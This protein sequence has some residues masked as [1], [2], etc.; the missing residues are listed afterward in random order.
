[1]NLSKIAQCLKELGYEKLTEL[2]KSS[3]L[4]IVKGRKLLIIVAPTGSGK[5]E[6]AVIPIMLKIAYSKIPPIA[7]LYITPLRALNRDIERRLDRL[8]RCFE[9]DVGVRHGDTPASVRKN[10]AQ[11][12]PHIL[13]TTPETLNFILVN[14]ELRKH[15]VNLQ[16]IVIDELRDLVESKRGL[17]LLTTLYILERVLGSDLSIIALSATLHEEELVK[18]LLSFGGKKDVEVLRDPSIRKFDIQV[19]IPRCETPLCKEVVKEIGDERLSARIAEIFERVSNEQYVLLFTN[20][21]TLAESLGALI[22]SLSE[23]LNLKLSIDVHHGSLSRQ[24]RERVEREFRERRLNLLVSTSSLELGIDIGHVEYVIQYMSPRQVIRLVQ[25]V[26]RSRHRL[27]EVSRGE[28][29]SI[30]NPLHLLESAVI[31]WRAINGDIEREVLVDRP[32]DVLAYALSLYIHLNPRGVSKS[33]LYAFIKEHPLFSGLEEREFN[34]VVNY[35]VYTR[36]V[37]E[38]GGLLY[39]TRKT[40]LYIYKTSMI[41]S[42][43]EVQVV[44]VASGKRVGALDEEYVVVNINPGDV[45]ILAGRPWKVVSYDDENKKLYVELARDS[46]EQVIIPHWEG[47]NIPVEYE[48]AQIVGEIVQYVKVYNTLPEHIKSLIQSENPINLDVLKELGDKNTITIDHVKE[49][50]LVL[51]NVYGGSK[52]NALLRDLLRYVLKT[53]F[54]Y[55]KVNAQSTPYCIVLQIQGSLLGAGKSPIEVVREVF[56]EIYRYADREVI[57]AVARDSNQLL[58][59]IYQVAQRFGAISPETTRVNRHLLEAFVDTIIGVEALKE[60]LIRDYDI[61]SFTN[62]AQRVARG[63]VKVIFRVYDKLRDHHITLLG[64]IELPVLK[65]LPPLDRTAFMEKLLNR[66]VAL[67]CIRCGYYREDKVQELLKL[68]KYACPKCGFATLA[69]VKG[70]AQKEIELVKKL[71][72]GDKLNQEERRIHEELVNRALILYNYGDKALLA[73]S[74]PGVNSREAASIIKNYLSGADLFQLLYEYEK[75]FLKIKKYIREG[76]QAKTK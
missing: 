23:K 51:I 41:P 52:V 24:H 75:R 39:P 27:G 56:E 9:L 70:D 76:E 17:L 61:D 54:P 68:E 48:T 67:L 71:R 21:R 44:E 69:V 6:A 50:N 25:R 47:E 63:E 32:L 34:E 57:K 31:A 49:F 62:L 46:E 45:L 8:S 65:S 22:R 13:I 73:L 28:I 72:R 16:Y 19:R 42:T 12:P 30:E 5:T 29:I 4:E 36:I 20:T 35:L 64:Y 26:G 38:E 40:L 55:L 53:R 2:Q 33:D 14:D 37:R 66:R 7:A 10:M 60:V 59:R 3:L 15:L 11:K 1:M 43:V 18:R 74:I 58:W